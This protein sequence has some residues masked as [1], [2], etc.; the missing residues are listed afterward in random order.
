VQ[1]SLLER[2]M[3]S[4]ETMAT[5]LARL[6]ALAGESRC[7][8]PALVDTHRP[9]G[10]EMRAIVA[11]PAP[12]GA[13]GDEAPGCTPVL[14]RFRP[15]VAVRVTLDHGRPA[16]VAIDR[17]GMPGGRVEQHAGPW[18][19]SGAWWDVSGA[20][21]DRDEWDVAFDDGTLGRLFRDRVSGVWFIEGVVD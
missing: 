14:R 4:A 11:P 10:F 18:R 6:R 20:R 21:W 15:P 8:A 5:L 3:P 16:H 13:A 2:A 12:P 7:G 19:T 17:R 1:Y 9:D